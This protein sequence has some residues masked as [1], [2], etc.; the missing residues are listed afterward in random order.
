MNGRLPQALLEQ[1]AQLQHDVRVLRDWAA[2]LD[3]SLQ[4]L[5]QSLRA[6][7]EGAAHE[8]PSDPDDPL[9]S[10][11]AA[12]ARYV[13]R[14]RTRAGLTRQQLAALTGLADSTLR[15][16]ETQRHRPMTQTLRRL[17][18]R[19][20]LLDVDATVETT[21]SFAHEEAPSP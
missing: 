13:L 4:D 21:P 19:L 15:N 6:F 3:E 7:S 8:E 16:I 11:P 10:E 5:E 20:P 18:E 14:I 12:L 17:R 1:C 9:P 2:L